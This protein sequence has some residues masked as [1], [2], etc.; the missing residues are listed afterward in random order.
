MNPEDPSDVAVQR[1]KRFQERAPAYVKMLLAAILSLTHDRELSNDVVQQTMVNYL[2]LREAENWQQEIENEPAYLRRIANN[3][4]ADR[5][6]AKARTEWMS[7]DDQLDDRLQKVLSEFKG[8]LDVEK[9]IY[10]DE[11]RKKIPFKIIFGGLS[12]YQR[13]LLW[14]HAVESMS[15]EEIAQEVNENVVIVRYEVQ[16]IYA[17]VRA[18][19]KKM[20]GNRTLFKS[21][22]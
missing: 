9:K 1:R 7:L 19:V 11:L 12:P 14:L 13:R 5:W 20:F 22:T 18:R 15:Y 17:T 3:L 10:L 21:G 8:G 4:L 6:K 16:R 2:S